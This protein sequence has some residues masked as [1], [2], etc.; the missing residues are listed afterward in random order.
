L[1]RPAPA[2]VQRDADG[3]EESDLIPSFTTIL[4][5]LDEQDAGRV[6]ELAASWEL[7]AGDVIDYESHGRRHSGWAACLVEPRHYVSTAP[8]GYHVAP[9][10]Q[11]VRILRG[12]EIAH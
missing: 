12:I 4:L 1:A 9:E 10:R 7:K 11:V 2:R 3:S 6:P 5:C 8:S